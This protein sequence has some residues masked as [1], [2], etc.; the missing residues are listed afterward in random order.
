MELQHCSNG[1]ALAWLFLGGDGGDTT[2]EKH[3]VVNGTPGANAQAISNTDG[4]FRLMGLI[5]MKSH[6]FSGI[7]WW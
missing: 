5:Q 2:A 7:H 4:F 6:R 3:A 1:D